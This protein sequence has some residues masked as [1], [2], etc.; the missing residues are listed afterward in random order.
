HEELRV[1]QKSIKFMPA[2]E[3]DII[4]QSLVPKVQFNL[5]L[6]EKERNDRA[7]VVLPFE[8]QGNGKPIQIYDGR[9]SLSG[10]KTENKETNAGKLQLTKDSGTGE[11]IYFRDS[12]DEMPDSDED[13]D[14]D[15]DI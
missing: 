3:D 12:D 11:I 9:K 7:K 2:S 15:L 13:P 8:H 4:S 10:S 6:S 5:Q 14:D 1:E